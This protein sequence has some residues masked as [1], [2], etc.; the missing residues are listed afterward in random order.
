M[1][2]LAQLK[3]IHLPATVPNY[4]LAPGWWLLAI[5]IIALLIYGVRKLYRYQCQRKTQKLAFKQLTSTD[6]NQQILRLLKWAAL[7]YFP[8][9]QVAPLSGEKFKNF[10]TASLPDKQQAKFLTLCDDEFAHIYQNNS[11]R[12]NQ[13][14]LHQAAQHWLRYALPPKQEMIKQLH[15]ATDFNHAVKNQGVKP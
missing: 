3:D 13:P 5:A 8:R 7:Q 11:P 15:S 2:P 10:L 14:S 6:N 1:D 4:P 12:Q 9:Q